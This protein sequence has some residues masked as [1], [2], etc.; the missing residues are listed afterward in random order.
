MAYQYK[1]TNLHYLRTSETLVSRTAPEMS[2]EE[3]KLMKK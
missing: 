2:G 3:N 1:T